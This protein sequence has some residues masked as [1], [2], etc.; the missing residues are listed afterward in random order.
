[1]SCPCLLLFIIF[2]IFFF[3]NACR[4]I[5][6]GVT[7]VNCASCIVCFTMREPRRERSMR[8][9]FTRWVIRVPSL[10]SFH[11]F[12]ACSSVSRAVVPR[13]HCP[14]M[15]S[16]LSHCLTMM[17]STDR[18][19]RCRTRTTMR[20]TGSRSRCRMRMKKATTRMAISC[21][22]GHVYC[23]QPLR[24]PAGFSSHDARGAPSPCGAQPPRA[25]SRLCPH[26][27]WRPSR[28]SA[29]KFHQESPRSASHLGGEPRASRVPSAAASAIPAAR[30]H[31]RRT[32]T[33]MST[34]PSR[35]ISDN[36][37]RLGPCRR[38]RNGMMKA[39]SRAGRR[40]RRPRRAAS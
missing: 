30:M 3:V 39:P 28:R 32:R 16:T 2:Y 1:M 17:M 27:S 26:P 24:T 7:N 6:P 34:C 21:V 19:S 13:P 40:W 38:G 12:A 29:R 22:V 9:A 31:P 11:D 23:F 37:R 4:V 33:R 10:C 25:P 20:W 18:R 8:V 35:R 14:M 36:E 15:M 5:A